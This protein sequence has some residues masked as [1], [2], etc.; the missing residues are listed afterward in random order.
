MEPI[1][2]LAT[3]PLKS[4]LALIRL[5]GDG[6][7]EAVAKSMRK[8]PENFSK[9]KIWVGY[10]Y[11]EEEIID[12]V[13]AFVYPAPNSF[14]GE[15][16]VEIS[17]HGSMIIVKEI[18]THFYALGIRQAVNGEF[19]SRAFYNGKVDLV[20]AEAINDMINATTKESKNLAL[21]S[22]K[23]DTS[24]LVFPILNWIDETLATLEVNIDY[25][26]Y[27]DI[28]ETNF[29]EIKVQIEEK[30]SDLK[31]L[32]KEGN[33]G[34]IIRNGIKIALIGEPNVGKSS[35]LNALLNEDK[36][37][38]SH[39]PGTTR[40]VVEGDLSLNGIPLHLLDTAGIRESDDY[41][42]TLGIL[43]SRKS[44]E[45]ADLVIWLSDASNKKE[46]QKAFEE[47]CK[48]KKLIHVFNKSDLIEGKDD[49]KLY[50][51]AAK[52]DI[53]PL[54][55]AIIDILGLDDNSFETPSFSNARELSLL[56][57]IKITLE[58]CKDSIENGMT[59]DLISASLQEARLYGK[60]LIGQ[61]VS[62]DLSDE[63]FS[64]FCVGK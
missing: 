44:I 4:A 2:A 1:I 64:R 19:S 37:I 22:L 10:L 3:P 23:G 5:S 12:E 53:E 28:E 27:T 14:T 9:K 21:L 43:K 58:E 17:S 47:V 60:E 13:V 7:F 15:D 61:D 41:V 29:K 45:E 11:H 6:V 56:E 30:I 20:E 62:M 52:N 55:K 26:E 31:K 50:V 40:D 16:V 54:K 8:D 35:L 24:K 49:G 25:P 18:L 59:S 34:K 51:S 63:I 36:A 32:I 48:G 46:N 57:K 38:V 33:Q 39:I 42:E